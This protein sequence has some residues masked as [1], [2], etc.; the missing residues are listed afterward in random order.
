MARK[1]VTAKAD[2]Q[3]FATW[4][5]Y[6]LEVYA[7]LNVMASTYR[8]YESVIQNH[9]IPEIGDKRMCDLSGNIFQ[10][11][12]DKKSTVGR[13]DGN[14]GGLSHKSLKNIYN[15]IHIALQS[16]VE[17]GVIEDTGIE[18]VKIPEYKAGSERFLTLEEQAILVNEVQGCGSLAAFGIELMILI[19]MKKHE[20]LSLKWSD[21]DFKENII[22]FSDRQFPLIDET[23]RK[24]TAHKKKQKIAMNQKSLIQSDDTYIITN[25]S[26]QKYT[27][28]GY[29]RLINQISKDCGIPFVTATALRNS[30]GANYLKLGLDIPTLSYA[31]G[32][33]DVRLTKKRYERLLS[34]I[35]GE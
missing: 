28:N 10:K 30:F 11:F 9:I 31:M 2:S 3:T 32:D 29:G 24:L 20:L 33:S 12:F 26:F 35:I 18:K 15:V 8:G 22:A 4:L 6:W 23:I 27:S 19:G 5:N 21:I 34:E 16:A 7:K 25:R 17:S 1:I 14:D 13:A